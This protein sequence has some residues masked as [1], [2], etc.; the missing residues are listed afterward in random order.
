MDIR[1]YDIRTYL[2][3]QWEY[4]SKRKERFCKN[5]KKIDIMGYIPYNQK[6]KRK[7]I[8]P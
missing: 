7:G 6:D 2:V 1:M 4:N 5:E 8:A 3:C